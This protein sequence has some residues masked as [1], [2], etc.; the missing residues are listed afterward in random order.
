M[1]TYNFR[2]KNFLIRG[3][4]QKIYD[5]K[6]KKFK[7]F[8]LTEPYGL[9]TKTDAVIA[10]KKTCIDNAGFVPI[11]PFESK[12]AN[13][14]VCVIISAWKSNEYI[15]ELLNSIQNGT[16]IPD[17]VLIG[18]DGC[19][20][21]LNFFKNS[22]LNV[23][24]FELQIFYSNTNYG[25]YI[26][27]NNL[28]NYAFNIMNCNYVVNIDSDDYIYYNYIECMLD[29]LKRFPNS[30]VAKSLRLNFHDKNF[31]DCK[32]S[33]YFCGINCYSK[34]TWND[35]GF[36]LE[37]RDYADAEWLYRA[38]SLN[39]DLY[40]SD[41]TMYYRRLHKNQITNFSNSK[42]LIDIK[43]IEKLMKSNFFIFKNDF[44]IIE[45][46]DKVIL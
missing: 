27:R 37:T 14:G 29:G 15:L 8:Y 18:I 34:S 16:I 11:N 23:F 22:K 9:I 24:D 46:F 44:L 38:L 7:K 13:D 41:S 39:Y 45:N 33:E 35:V 10:G 30:I 19:L 1:N 3:K 36:Y 6:F 31:N 2:G 21:T 20:E 12:K 28:C 4:N 25:T 32:I 17:L 5:S 43:D 40:L 42:T 26:I